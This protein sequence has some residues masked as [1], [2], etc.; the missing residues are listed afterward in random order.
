MTTM[1]GRFNRY[2]K[3][4]KEFVNEWCTCIVDYVPFRSYLFYH[5]DRMGVQF[6]GWNGTPSQVN[7]DPY[8][9]Y[10]M[11]D[12]CDGF[13]GFY[14]THPPHLGL[15]RPSQIDIDTMNAWVSCLCRPLLCYIDN[16]WSIACWMFDQYGHFRMRDLE[17]LNDPL[18]D[19][20]IQISRQ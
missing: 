6:C 1:I 2:L 12:N 20:R 8:W 13:A 19:E 5:P 10:Q 17:P 15:A 11:E 18:K 3:H 7:F 16:G 14:H 9:V 4:K